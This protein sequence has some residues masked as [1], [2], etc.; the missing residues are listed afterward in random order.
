M[1]EV[2]LNN[3]LEDFNTRLES[4]EEQVNRIE[5][6]SEDLNS[7][8]AKSE[9]AVEKI[10]VHFTS[11]KEASGSRKAVGRGLVGLTKEWERG[12][13]HANQSVIPGSTGP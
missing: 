10:G 4:L 11:A 13:P 12:V 1:E 6:R 3:I 9:K 7:R 8:L 2:V 5:R